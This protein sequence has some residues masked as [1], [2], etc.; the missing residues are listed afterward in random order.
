VPRFLQFEEAM[1]KKRQDQWDREA[2]ARRRLMAEV[3]LM[4]RAQLEMKR[5]TTDAERERN[6]A[7]AEAL[8]HRLRAMTEEEARQRESR[9]AELSDHQAFLLSQMEARAKAAAAKQQM[10]FLENKL[11]KREEE[12]YVA[13]VQ[14]VL[15]SAA[16]ESQF[17]RKKAQWWVQTLVVDRCRGRVD[18]CVFLSGGPRY[19]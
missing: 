8:C 17:K 7:E 18:L 15:E 10:E 9:K 19:F 6:A 14:S 5:A 16:P 11:M 2:E 1:W 13:R 3:D 12:K 4:R